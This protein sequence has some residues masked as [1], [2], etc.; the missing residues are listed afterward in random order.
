MKVR[1][2]YTTEWTD[3][4]RRVLRAYYG[5]SGLASRAEIQTFLRKNGEDGGVSFVDMAYDMRGRLAKEGWMEAAEAIERA[6][7]A[8]SYPGGEND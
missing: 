6:N 5:E 3:Y 1:V 4:Q 8:E 2:S 7:A